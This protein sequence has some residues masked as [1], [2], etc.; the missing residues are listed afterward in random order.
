L[1]Y[2]KNMSALEAYLPL[3]WLVAQLL[4][5]LEAWLHLKAAELAT[6]LLVSALLAVAFAWRAAGLGLNS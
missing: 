5:K 1:T 3:P 4:F 6:L 2:L